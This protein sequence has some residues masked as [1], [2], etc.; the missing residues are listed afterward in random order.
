M[1]TIK[2][3]YQRFLEHPNIVTDSRQCKPN[4]LFFAL[5]GD[6]FDGNKF[7]E[8]ALVDGCNY[9]IVD[10]IELGKNPRII[11]VDDVLKA[12]QQLAQYHR[13]Q[14]AI[15]IIGITGTNGKTT[16][17]ELINVVLS[18]K[19]TVVATK[20]NLNNHIGVP[21]TLLTMNG[22]TEIGI[23]EMGANHQGEIMQL[24]EIADPDF[25]IITNIG[26]AHIE[27]FGS[28]E[29]VKK[30]KKELYDYILKKQG[31]LF[32]NAQDELLMSLSNDH[33]RE[34]Y[35]STNQIF[36]T[37]IRVDPFLNFTLH[38]TVSQEK[39]EVT[40]SI[41]GKYN[42]NNALAASCI[43]N[44]FGVALP[45]IASALNDYIPTN[46]RSQLIK[47][48]RNDIIMDA[49]NANP[50]SMKVAIENF[51]AIEHPNKVVILGGMKELGE[52]SIEAHD[53]LFTKITQG[54][55]SKIIL[56]GD[57]FQPFKNTDNVMWYSSSELLIPALQDADIRNTLILI[58][59][60]RSNR[61]EMI[62]PYL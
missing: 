28:Y 8:Q 24:C 29:G 49:Y 37:E 1:E 39:E 27:G 9:A 59:G 23:V 53:Q 4:S 41:I 50:S 40:M 46:N 55:F 14:L 21:L 33:K 58:K 44:Y 10:D 42:I 13:K 36:A 6:K 35:S 34:L 15:P 11:V 3:I 56:I 57:E 61:L 45:D 32:V 18:K 54:G 25:G 22:Q 2:L 48:E 38:N 12:L 62:L 26:H 47:T 19:Y 20:G 16:T 5:K 43:G 17:K 51:N 31:T 30:T 52:T 7:A 60:S